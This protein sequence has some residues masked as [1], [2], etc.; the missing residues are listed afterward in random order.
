M[1]NELEGEMDKKETGRESIPNDDFLKDIPNNRQGEVV[2]RYLAMQKIT[3]EMFKDIE[4]GNLLPYK[5]GAIIAD[6]LAFVS[7]L[8]LF[9][10]ELATAHMLKATG[11]SVKDRQQASRNEERQPNGR[12]AK[13]TQEDFSDILGDK[14]TM[15]TLQ[16]LAT[17]N[18]DAIQQP[19]SPEFIEKIW[20]FFRHALAHDI[21]GKNEL[22]SMS[23]NLAGYTVEILK[24]KLNNEK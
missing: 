4:N 8:A 23:K 7:A 22:L 14:E 10:S 15:Q 24:G 12:D 16:H 11:N 6:C 21:L 18:F 2:R 3:T 9:S 1:K 17:G 19:D 13:G 20:K 5:S